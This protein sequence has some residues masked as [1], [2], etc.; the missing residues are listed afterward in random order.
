MHEEINYRLVATQVGDLL[1]YST[2]VNEV[3]RIGKSV[4]KI[5]KENFPND[6]ITSVRAASVYNGFFHWRKYQ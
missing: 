4:L 1:K 6:S 3:D 2:T 5:N